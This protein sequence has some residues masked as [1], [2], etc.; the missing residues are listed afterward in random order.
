MHA[1]STTPREVSRAVL[2]C[3]CDAESRRRPD[4]Y[5]VVAQSATRSVQDRRTPQNCAIS[6]VIWSMVSSSCMLRRLACS[7]TY[8][9]NAAL[10]TGDRYRRNHAS[11]STRTTQK[12]LVCTSHGQNHRYRVVR[13]RAVAADPRSFSSR[14]NTPSQRNGHYLPGIP[15]TRPFPC[16]QAPRR[17]LRRWLD[18]G[19]RR[20]G[21]C[22]PQPGSRLAERH[23]D[24]LRCHG[25][26]SHR[27]Q[28]VR[29]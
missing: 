20:P 15:A 9:F 18:R 6:S 14:P 10:R 29:A 5:Q 19:Y 16:R 4:L 8:R 11:T 7:F 23:V 26:R 12:L 3:C 24:S 17:E 27:A 25:C 1:R 21:A 13:L 28:L 22:H 2:L